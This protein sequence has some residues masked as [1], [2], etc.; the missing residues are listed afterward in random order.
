MR[1]D[2]DFD[3]IDEV[4]YDMYDVI[5]W[6]TED[7]A[8]KFSFNLALE[9]LEK[10]EIDRC[11]WMLKKAIEQSPDGS[12]IN[13]AI[14]QLLIRTKL[15]VE[16]IACLNHLHEF[17]FSNPASTNNLIRCYIDSENYSKAE[18]ICSVALIGSLDEFAVDNLHS[19]AL[20]RHKQGRNLEAIALQQQ[21]IELSRILGID[22]ESDSFVYW[23]LSLYL[24]SAGLI[25]E[26]LNAA[27]IGYKETPHAD[28]DWEGRISRL[29]NWS[30]AQE[31]IN[32]SENS[33]ALT[34]LT[35]LEQWFKAGVFWHK[36]IPKDYFYGTREFLDEL[37]QNGATWSDESVLLFDEYWLEE[38]SLE[39]SLAR[40]ESLSSHIHLQPSWPVYL[41]TP[42]ISIAMTINRDYLLAWVGKGLEGLMVGVNVK[43]WDVYHAED[44]DARFAVGAVLNWFL[45]C[46]LNISSHEMFDRMPNKWSEIERPWEPKYLTTWSTTTIFHD[47]IENMRRY[48]DRR[49]PIAHRVR[50]HIRTLSERQPTDEARENAPAYIRRNMG[51]TDTFVRSYTKSGDLGAEKLLIH[52]STK[53]SLADFLGTAPLFE[54]D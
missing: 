4:F 24:Q 14:Y 27:Q 40:V 41:E 17:G 15:F 47:D 31:S 11:V 42:D 1:N 43:T 3:F 54:S 49:P 8:I 9:S 25:N 46:S 45:D 7:P 48:V 37:C 50:G 51:P 36:D 34:G 30:T 6:E 44:S 21:V 38:D 33:H 39:E 12:G 52:L 13:H 20:V 19:L 32:D 16:A 28:T 29:K 26:S 22:F 35:E 10:H 53:S 18:E 5:E 2:I 23:N